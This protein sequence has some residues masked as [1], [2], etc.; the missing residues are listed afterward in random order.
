MS[1]AVLF[2]IVRNGNNRNGPE[3]EKLMDGVCLRW[4]TCQIL[5]IIRESLEHRGKRE[6][7]IKEV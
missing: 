6:D 2:L 3:V 4:A 5:S 1:F 7:V